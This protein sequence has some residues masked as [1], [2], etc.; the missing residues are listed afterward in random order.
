MSVSKAWYITCDNCGD[1][2]AIDTKSP[3]AARQLA[4]TVD[5]FTR[6]KV[7]DTHDDKH[8]ADLCMA[9]R[10][11]PVLDGV[12]PEWTTDMALEAIERGWSMK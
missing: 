7:K 5:G 2:A 9:C 3:K 8:L 6:R 11:I 10:D 4:R 1:P 12:R